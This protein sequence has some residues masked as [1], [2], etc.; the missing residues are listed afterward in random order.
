MPVTLAFDA[1]SRP[2]R[3]VH[4]VAEQ[5]A[6]FGRRWSRLLDRIPEQEPELRADGTES[7]GRCERQIQLQAPWQ[8]EDAIQC[9]AARQ[10]E[11][12]DGSVLFDETL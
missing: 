9:R 1:D 8:Q 6:N 12:V 7:G 4:A 3:V 10:I 2:D 5:L 11:Q